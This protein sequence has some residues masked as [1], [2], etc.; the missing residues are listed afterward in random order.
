MVQEA[1]VAIAISNSGETE[2]VLA[3][4][5][6]LRARDVQVVSVVGN[7]DSTLALRS[8]A[9][10][11][12]RADAEACP[13]NLAPT[14]STTVALALCDALAIA[15]M[16]AK[17]ITSTA[18]ARN[19]PSGRLG[20]RL[21]LRV[22]DLMVAAAAVPAL[23][24][25]RRAARG[26]PGDRQGRRG[27]RRRSSTPDGLVGIV[28]DG[29]VRRAIEHGG[30]E[31][32]LR[33]PVRRLMTPDPVRD[34][35]DV[36]RLRRAAAHGGPAVADL[37]AAR[38]HRG[39]GARRDAAAPRPRARRAMTAAARPRLLAVV[40]VRMSATRLPGKPLLLLD[41]R[42]VVQRVHDAV[43][44]SGLFDEVVV[45]TDDERIADEVASFGGTVRMTSDRARDG[46]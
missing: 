45:A 24:A 42:T 44:D 25:G 4:L 7:T 19:H 29:D 40:P 23:L 1:D 39:R 17:G 12:A 27:V 46:Q 3:L 2:E 5:P 15:V 13:L 8:A 36:A 20:R 32:L 35:A 21:S 30:D 34:G 37:G 14:C 18:F 22:S 33:T 41:G 38:R 16:D 31:D 9:V 43:Q 10:L 28:T 26:R 11:D 6:Y